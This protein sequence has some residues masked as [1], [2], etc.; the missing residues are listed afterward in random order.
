MKTVSDIMEVDTR[1]GRFQAVERDIIT[2]AIGMPGFESCTRFVL[3]GGPDMQPFTCLQ[4]LDEPRPSFLVIDPHLL[5]PSYQ[6]PLSPLDLRRLEVRGGEPLLWLATVRI[7]A[8]EDATVNLRAPIVV[9][10]RHML[11][12]QTLPHDSPHRHDH[13]LRLEAASAGLHP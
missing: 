8:G 3:V 4:G 7:G 11:A 9:N 1:F 2:M 6:N 13:P 5:V 10:P 12:L